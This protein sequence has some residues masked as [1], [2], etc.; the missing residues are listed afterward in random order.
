MPPNK[1]LTTY[2]LTEDDWPAKTPQ[3]ADGNASVTTIAAIAAGDCYEIDSS[4]FQF[5]QFRLVFGATQGADRPIAF[6]LI[7]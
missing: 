7:G 5:D 2:G 4:C 6:N 3:G 1:D